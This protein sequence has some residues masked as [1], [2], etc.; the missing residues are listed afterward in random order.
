MFKIIVA[1][2]VHVTATW[3][4]FISIAYCGI[5]E[6]IPH[7]ICKYLEDQGF[8]T[9][10]YKVLM[11][12]DYFA[13]SPY[14]EVGTGSPPNNI[15]FYVDGKKE[16]VTSVYLTLNVNDTLDAKKSN[17]ELMRVCKILSLKA[18]GEEIPKDVKAALSNRKAG[19]WKS[20]EGYTFKVEKVN[21][22][23]KRKGYSLTFKIE[24]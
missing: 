18:T 3:A 15:A 9:Q 20:K 14:K 2:L 13:C 12:D 1:F 22:S 19:E 23:G 6:D 5:K 11:D 4:F 16:F 17:L 24:K 10:G 7:S 21:F 8:V